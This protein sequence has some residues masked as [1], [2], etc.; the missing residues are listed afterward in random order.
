MVRLQADGRLSGARALF[1]SRA[2]YL[3]FGGLFPRPPPDGIPG[4]LLG[5]L[6]GT[7]VLVGALGAVL[8][9]AIAISVTC[10]QAARV[11]AP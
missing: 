3:L 8:F 2:G 9:V 11:R 1:C 6:C 5:A 7:G 4:F 10:Q